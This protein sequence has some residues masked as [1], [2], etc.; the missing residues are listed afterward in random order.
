[1]SQVML[2]GDPV[3]IGGTFPKV[4]DDVKDFNLANNKREDVTLEIFSGQKKV[5]NIFPSID[6]PTCALSVK[7]FNQEVSHLSNTVVLCVS[8]DLPFAQK[9][10]C[11]AEGTD[12]IIT[13][14]SY[15]NNEKFSND[16]GVAI[17]DTSLKGLTS[18]AVI[19]LDENNKV[20]HSELVAEITEEPNYEAALSVLK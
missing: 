16:Y 2:K 15:R 7:R 13:L 17:L 18:R 3:S 11:G 8:A 4:G 6:T 10:F 1:M 19:V 5:I 9:R 20:I 12:K 14:S